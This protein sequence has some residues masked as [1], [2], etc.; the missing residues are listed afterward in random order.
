MPCLS[1][2]FIFIFLNSFNQSFFNHSFIKL[3]IQRIFRWTH[4]KT[5]LSLSGKCKC[6]PLRF[7]GVGA[8]LFIVYTIIQGS[9]F[10]LR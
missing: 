5:F 4:Y 7:W 2:I 8:N 10:E 9:S 3:P 1:F 6:I